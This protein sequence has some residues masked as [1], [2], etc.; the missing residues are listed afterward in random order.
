MLQGDSEAALA[1]CD[2]SAGD[3]T[4]AQGAFD[5]IALLSVYA[6]GALQLGRLE[7]ARLLS[8]SRRRGA[9]Q[10]AKYELALTLDALAALARMTG[11]EVGRLE[12]ERD[13]ILERLGAVSIPEIPLLQIATPAG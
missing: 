6:D 2:G 4:V 10:N 3:R 9:E 8:V 5:V 1:F 11:A 12:K 13:A 7:E